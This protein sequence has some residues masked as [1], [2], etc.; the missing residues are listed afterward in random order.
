MLKPR[1][2]K[3]LL[4]YIIP[5][6][7]LLSLKADGW[8]SFLT[9]LVA[10]CIIPLLELIAPSRTDNFTESE[11]FSRNNIIFFDVLLFLNIP[12]VYCIVYIYGHGVQNNAW[13]TMEWWGK[14]LSIGIMLGS[15][16]INVAHELGHKKGL[17]Y[18]WAARI[19]LIPALYV[20]FMTEHNYGHHS[21]V[22]TKEDPAT[23]RYGEW[24]YI[25]WFRSIIMG[26]ISA[27]KLRLQHLSHSPNFMQILMHP[28]AEFIILPV[29]YI[30]GIQ[31]LF[32]TSAALS[33]VFSA[34]TGILLLETINYIE[35][36]GL[37]RK[38]I[39]QNRYEPVE[40][41][42]SWNSNHEIGRVVLYELTRHSDHHYKAHK[43][44][45]NLDHHDESPQLPFGYPTSILL[46]LIPPL[47]FTIMNPLVQDWR[48]KNP[49]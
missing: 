37:T 29:L 17:L 23:S 19:L 30:M 7:A 45:Q 20:H 5:L 31:F 3:Y 32:G 33:L 26:F 28:V 49:S 18:K 11:Q 14:T 16:A 39:N 46:A 48:Q 25:F 47:W 9:V 15:N 34:C 13:T 42:H 40:S 10:F 27:W 44:Y 36:Y 41:F 43:K 24:L 6:T 1:D 22:G 8:P 4:A 12:L 21:R 35:H 38:K 2:V